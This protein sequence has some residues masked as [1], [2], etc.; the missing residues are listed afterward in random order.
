VQAGRAEPP[1]AA[2][3]TLLAVSERA[4]GSASGAATTSDELVAQ[5][6]VL[7]RVAAAN[8]ELR[9]EGS[10]AGD[11]MVAALKA[12][13]AIDQVPTVGR[14]RRLKGV[15]MRVA[16]LFL[17]DQATFN[18]ATTVAFE[19]TFAQLE[20]LAARLDHLERSLDELRSGTP[21]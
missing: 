16:R 15:V 1:V 20:A 4:A 19:D 11:E 17:R 2:G 9:C 7:A 21:S 6:R 8:D 14:F 5:A 13:A 3:A 10:A 18:R 12:R